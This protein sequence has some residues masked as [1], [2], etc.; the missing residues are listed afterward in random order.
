MP[1]SYA[2]HKP[3][4]GIAYSPQCAVIYGFFTNSA[5]NLGSDL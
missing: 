4:F 5:S 3:G 1:K 2:V